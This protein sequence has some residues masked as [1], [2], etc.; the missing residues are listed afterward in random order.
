M[1]TD[2]T[3]EYYPQRASAGLIVTEATQISPEGQGYLDTPGIFS[4]EQ[5]AGWK[6]VTDGVH[7]GRAAE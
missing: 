4:A 1:P 2:L 7:A 3:V 5:V 6:R